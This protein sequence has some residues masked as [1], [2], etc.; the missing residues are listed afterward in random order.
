M[1]KHSGFKNPGNRVREEVFILVDTQAGNVK[2]PDVMSLIDDNSMHIDQLED[3]T[4]N[5]RFPRT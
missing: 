5:D 2:H 1:L 4:K 3:M